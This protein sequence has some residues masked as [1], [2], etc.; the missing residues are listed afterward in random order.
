MGEYKEG[1]PEGKG[2]YLWAN[3]SY[4]DGM[5]KKGL[6]SCKGKWKKYI[7]EI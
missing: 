1:K 4:Y 6:K 2:V 3:G 5:F 7:N